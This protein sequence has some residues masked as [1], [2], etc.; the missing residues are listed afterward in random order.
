MSTNILTCSCDNVIS[1]NSP[2]YWKY[3]GQGTDYQLLVG[4]MYI[5]VFSLSGIPLGMLNSQSNT[6]TEVYNHCISNGV[7]PR[8]SCISFVMECAFRFNIGIEQ[9]QQK[10]LFGVMYGCLERDDHVFGPSNR[11]L[12]FSGCSFSIRHFVSEIFCPIADNTPWLL[13][14]R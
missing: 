4:P 12:A 11:I 9:H 13:M 8:C 2:C 7:M 3:T 14:Y 6:T 1:E 5:I 10:A